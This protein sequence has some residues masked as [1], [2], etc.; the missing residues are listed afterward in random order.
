[1]QD[2][3]INIL[4]ICH[5]LFGCIFYRGPGSV[6]GIATGFGLDCPGIESRWKRDFPHLSIPNLG[7]TQPPVQWIPGFSRGVKSGRGVT[8][9]R[10]SLLV[11]WSR[12]SRAIP[13]LPLWGRTACRE[14]Q[15][16]YK[17]DLY[18][19]YFLLHI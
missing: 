9:T 8:L 11:P 4:P 13:L 6:V 10:H 12:K 7:L 15:C 5:I 16:L 19:Y 17:S 3:S 1:M 14:P 18:L 2:C